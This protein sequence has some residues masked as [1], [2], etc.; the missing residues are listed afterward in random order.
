[1]T[2]TLIAEFDAET[3]FL[4]GR[5]T[6]EL[7]KQAVPD[8]APRMVM[9]CDPA[10]YMQHVAALVDFGVPATRFYK[11]QFQIGAES[12]EDDGEQ[13][14]LTIRQPLNTL[15]VPEGISLLAALESHKIT[16]NSA[17]RAGVCG[18]CNTK[19]HSGDYT[20]S[21]AM[22]LTAEEIAQDYVLAYS[23]QLHG[24]TVLA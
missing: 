23:F 10:P 4:A 19:V 12:L 7:L 20:T 16:V 24:D 5:L 6:L 13:L 11:E 3:G 14:T 1:M 9:T 8:L 15:R 22:T 2:L 17:C 21:S 18:S